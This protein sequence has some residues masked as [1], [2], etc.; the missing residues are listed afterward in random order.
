VTYDDPIGNVELLCVIFYEPS[1][2]LIVRNLT[3][4]DLV[5]V[6]FDKVQELL[7]KSEAIVEIDS[8]RSSQVKL[9]NN[10]VTI[11][12]KDSQ[13]VQHRR[14]RPILRAPAVELRFVVV[15]ESVGGLPDCPTYFDADESPEDRSR[16]QGSGQRFESRVFFQL[17]VPP[18][19]EHEGL[20]R[21]VL[22]DSDFV[23]SP[24]AAQVLDKSDVVALLFLI[25][26]VIA[27]LGQL[28]VNEVDSAPLLVGLRLQSLHTGL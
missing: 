5:C 8:F 2:S 13:M 25:R 18:Q 17:F 14:Q 16:R 20:C 9:R 19:D 11:R 21:A 26:S 4:I 28:T 1:H 15:V 12:M 22:D 10:L 27:V 6:I 3:L 7:Q 24:D 23:V